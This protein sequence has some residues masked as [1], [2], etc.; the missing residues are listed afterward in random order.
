[1]RLISNTFLN[2]LDQFLD[3]HPEII[4]VE[5]GRNILRIINT[6]TPLDAYK[7]FLNGYTQP[8]R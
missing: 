3:A 5:E 2:E 7:Y 1:M 6:S 4:T 8:A